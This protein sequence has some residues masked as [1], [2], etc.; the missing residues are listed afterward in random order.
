M[1][2]KIEPGWKRH[3]ADQFDLPYFKA[4]TDRVRADYADPSV[5]VYPRAP[6]FSPPSMPLLSTTPRWS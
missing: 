2:V 5:T 6:R 4:L 3:L 1:D